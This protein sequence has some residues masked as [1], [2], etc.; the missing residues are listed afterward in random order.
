ML[1]AALLIL[2]IADKPVCSK[3]T[4]G[5]MW[6]GIANQ[7]KMALLALARAGTLEMC[8]ATTWSYKWQGL[9]VNIRRS[10]R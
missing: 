5:Q 1:S 8:V 4:E 9:T 3:K 10:G 7:D 2:M 6:P